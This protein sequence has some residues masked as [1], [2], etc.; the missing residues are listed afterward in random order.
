[1]FSE[2]DTLGLNE[3]EFFLPFL[4]MYLEVDDLTDEGTGVPESGESV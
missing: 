4:V 2:D 1:L 3:K